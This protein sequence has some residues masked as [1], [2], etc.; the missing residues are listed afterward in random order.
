VLL[1]ADWMI[2]HSAF[3]TKRSLKTYDIQVKKYLEY[4]KNCN[5][6]K[7]ENFKFIL[8][9]NARR[10]FNSINHQKKITYTLNKLKKLRFIK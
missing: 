10:E 4:W 2:W 8:I 1:L 6:L 5:F 3:K 7:K 9:I